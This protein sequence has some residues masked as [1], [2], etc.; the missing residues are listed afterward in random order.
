MQQSIR[1]EK[2]RKVGLCFIKSF[3]MIINYFFV[4]QDHLQPN[5]W[6]LISGWRKKYQR[7]SREQQITRNGK[8]Q[9]L[10]QKQFQSFSNEYNTNNFFYWQNVDIWRLIKV[11]YKIS[12]QFVLVPTLKIHSCRFA[13]DPIYLCLYKNNTLKVSLSY[14]QEKSTYLPVKFVSFLKSR[15]IYKHNYCF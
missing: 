15:L 1:K 9:D 6:F 8:L 11:N 10:F 2:L 3:N 7:G 13:N 5:F 4:L 12:M 14:S